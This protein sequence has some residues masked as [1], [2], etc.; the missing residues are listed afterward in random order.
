[1]LLNG[2]GNATIKAKPGYGSIL[3]KFDIEGNLLDLETE[4]NKNGNWDERFDG[5]KIKKFDVV[6]TNPP[7]GD[8]RAFIPKDKKDIEII[9]CYELWNKYNAK[10]IDLGVIFL[11]NSYHIPKGKWSNGYCSFKFYCFH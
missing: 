11:E 1:M 4:I 2:D 6:L 9:S 3:T 8:D 5:K 10:K 7:F